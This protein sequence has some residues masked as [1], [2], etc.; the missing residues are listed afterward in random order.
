MLITQ[1]RFTKEQAMKYGLTETLIGR[2]GCGGFDD[3]YSVNVFGPHIMIQGY[4]TY[5]FLEQPKDR[6]TKV[7]KIL[8][9]VTKMIESGDFLN[10]YS[11]IVVIKS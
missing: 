6:N 1:I 11:G 4:T 5:E 10:Q 8:S 9:A 3:H 2:P 7:K